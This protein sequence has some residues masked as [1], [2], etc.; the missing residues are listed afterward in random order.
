[1]NR[2]VVGAAAAALVFLRPLAASAQP[3]SCPACSS[4][5]EVAVD[6]GPR[7]G[8]SVNAD[9]WLFGGQLRTGL[10]CLGGLGIGPAFMIGVGGNYLTLRS[11]GR[12]D[13]MW[14]LDD[15]HVF[16]IF[17]AVGASVL[18]YMPV[19]PFASFCDRTDLDECWGYEVGTE[20]GGGIRYRQLG[21]DAFVGFGE[22]PVVTIMASV[23]FPLV[24]REGQP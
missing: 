1:M 6:A 22:L 12:L 3:P 19:G 17:P 14:W 4:S 16:G 7:L 11:S 10:P 5:C 8:L 9:Q 2:G 18:Y 15:A 21:V 24:E 23:S 20:L 13:Y